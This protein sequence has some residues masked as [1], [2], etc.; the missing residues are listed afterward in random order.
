MTARASRPPFWAPLERDEALQEIMDDPDCDLALLQ[1]TYA[2]FGTLN[3][4]LSGWSRAWREVLLPAARRALRDRGH[5]T[6]LD[7]GCGGGDLPRRF[8]A[9]ANRD[10]VPLTITAID[11]DDR[12]LAYARS[13]PTPPCVRYE[14]WHTRD[15]ARRGETFDLVVSNHVLHHVTSEDLTTFLG[16]TVALTREVAL[17]ADLFR[18]RLALPAFWLFSLPFRGSLLREDGRRSIH[19]AWTPRD[20]KPHLPPRVEANRRGRFRLWVTF[21]AREEAAS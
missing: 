4:L 14:P 2:Q 12:A 1:A 8:A 18:T 5:V 3:D 11:P 19:R 20:L 13:R 15:L 21:D 17:H 7:V 16:E 10:G 6:M 9:W